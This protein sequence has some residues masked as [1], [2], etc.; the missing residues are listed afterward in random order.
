MPKD[1]YEL[2]IISGARSP[3]LT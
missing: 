2:C 1:E 3:R